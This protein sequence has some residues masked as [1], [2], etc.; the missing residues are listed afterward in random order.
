MIKFQIHLLKV[1]KIF[2]KVRF[3]ISYI[4][5]VLSF[6]IYSG[7]EW[8]PQWPKNIEYMGQL[9]AVSIDP[10]GNVAIFHR[11]SRVWG[12]T[13][14]NIQN[15]FNKEEGPIRE[16]TVVLFNKVGERI[17]EWGAYK[18]YLPHGLTIDMHGNY[19]ITDV[20]LHQVLK[21]DAKDIEMMKDLP[22]SRKR[23]YN[24]EKH[25]RPSLILGEAFVPGNDDKRFCKPTA[26]AVENN[27]DFFVS[28]GYCNARILKFNAKGERILHWG[29]GRYMHFI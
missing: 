17:L 20:A 6:F 12:S 3:K 7:I 4:L 13:T 25:L 23:Q 15:I 26:V 27:G 21:F 5:Y 28:D 18:F 10:N 9:S 16:N 14:F 29:R 8:N 19:W 1:N 24:Q 2:I 11:G 22:S